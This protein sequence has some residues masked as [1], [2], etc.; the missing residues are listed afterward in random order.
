MP[1]NWD[2]NN[3]SCM[4][5]HKKNLQV[6]RCPASRLCSSLKMDIS[7]QVTPVLVPKTKAGLHGTNQHTNDDYMILIQLFFIPLH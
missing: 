5:A 7:Q 3:G 2:A 1:L 4:F 6:V